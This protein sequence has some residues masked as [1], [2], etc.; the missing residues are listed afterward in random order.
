MS[1]AGAGPSAVCQRIAPLLA[2][3]ATSLPLPPPTESLPPPPTYSTCD[4]LLSWAIV[5][6]AIAGVL[7]TP[8]VPPQLAGSAGVVVP[9]GVFQSTAPDACIVD[10]PW[11]VVVHV[12]AQS[13]YSLP[14][15]EPEYTTPLSTTGCV[16]MA[17]PPRLTG[18]PGRWARLNALT[19]S[20]V[21][22][23]VKPSRPE[24]CRYCAHSSG[25]TACWAAW[26]GAALG[27]DSGVV[28]WLA[29]RP[30]RNTATARAAM[31]A[32]A[33]MKRRSS[34]VVASTCVSSLG[35]MCS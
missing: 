14:S 21:L 13:A 6:V 32:P 30:D 20:M 24:S 18:H 17:L 28:A 19:A 33:Q 23:D 11:L 16:E 25:D 31:A 22:S 15:H 10:C 3:S 7:A 26:A 9:S 35:R 12:A 1:V 34:T 29:A 5:T 27:I 2:S 4:G 8:M